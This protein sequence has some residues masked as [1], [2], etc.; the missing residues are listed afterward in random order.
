MNAARAGIAAAACV[1]LVPSLLSAQTG[2]LG[3]PTFRVGL[4]ARAVA[5]VGTAE[6]LAVTAALTARI[7]RETGLFR[8]AKTTTFVDSSDLQISLEKGALDFV[9]MTGLEYA[10]FG[11]RLGIDPA[12]IPATSSGDSYSVALVVR[13]ES[14]LT[15]LADLQGL[16]LLSSKDQSRSAQAMWID[17]EVMKAGFNGAAGFFSSLKEA[18]NPSA[19]ILSVFFGQ[20]DACLTTMP[21]LDLAREMNPQLDR[22]LVVLQQSQDFAGG[23]LGFR[24][25]YPNA[26]RDKV[27]GVL[28]R[29]HQDAEGRQLLQ[30]F[31]TNRLVP[32]RPALLENSKAL[33]LEHQRQ[34]TRR[35]GKAL[36]A[37]GRPR[38]R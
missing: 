34:V 20:T 24:S 27:V 14:G 32:F 1:V 35:D 15:R 9:L 28:V 25:G 19:A 21:A 36:P 18:R 10:D 7:A 22:K 3:L 6:T 26:L 12:L 17:T 30:L 5:A 16:A 2:A 38:P 29:L 13:R 11:V 33:A 4:S 37:K 31:A 8:D 23:V